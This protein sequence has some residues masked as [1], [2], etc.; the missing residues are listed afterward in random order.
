MNI[1]KTKTFHT[2]RKTVRTQ[3]CKYPCFV[4][5]K[6][7]KKES[8]FYVIFPVFRWLRHAD[9]IYVCNY[10][11]AFKTKL[12]KESIKCTKCETCVHK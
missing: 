10:K 12:F 2:G 6:G 11:L 5:G 9:S 3:A 8:R 7:A 1:N 4:C